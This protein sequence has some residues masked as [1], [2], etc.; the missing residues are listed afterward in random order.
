MRDGREEYSS[1]VF[2]NI[3]TFTLQKS[4]SCSDVNTSC[5]TSAHEPS[6]STCR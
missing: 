2:N 5:I 4:I 3:P 1:I 6:G